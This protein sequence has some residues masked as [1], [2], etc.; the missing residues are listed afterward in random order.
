MNLLVV[1]SSYP[2][3]GYV[4]AGAFNERSVQALKQLGHDVEVLAPRPY[5]PR[6]LALCN[7]RWK[8]YGKIAGR[9]DHAGVAVYRPAYLQVPFVGGAFWSDRGAYVC[10]GAKA[11]GRHQEK[12]YDAI[13]SFNLVGAGGLAW[14]LARRLGIPAA[15][16]ATGN[17]VRFPA[18]SSFGRA[19]G[20]ALQHLEA[21]FYQ[22]AEL[23][24]KAAEL[25]GV[26]L[27]QLAAERHVVLPRGIER[28]P[29]ISEHARLS[30]RQDLGLR[31][32]QLLVLYIGRIVKAKGVFELVEALSIAGRDYPRIV[33]LL[34]GAK[35]G[36]DD[37]AEL[38]STLS[39]KPGLGR[40]VRVLPECPPGK[41]WE[42]LNA[43]DIFAFP[44]HREGL[45]NS[46]LEA[47]AVG[48]PA[49][50]S[51]I[52]PILEIDG[53]TGALKVVPRLNIQS[54]AE[55][56]GE[57]ATSPEKRRAIGEKGKKRVLSH[58][59]AQDKMAEAVQK[60]SAVV[61]EHRRRAA[62]QRHTRTVSPRLS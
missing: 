19:V 12:H 44:S 24:Q 15:G 55:A 8:A 33:C 16:W 56:I 14:R 5:V 9:G 38:N 58:Y 20:R 50:A 4:S 27:E 7:S 36:F 35:T 49:V 1:V 34:V 47:M 62:L 25:C 51:A 43:A 10:C 32:D 17:D 31:D 13:L 42:Y 53:G 21:V 48:V 22:S 30:F 45:P 57:L 2:H 41:V 39:Q 54:L 18:R 52:P 46:L 29:R 11:E 60:L 40:T 3:A 28:P 59:L 26:A 6:G 37:S 61:D 23:R